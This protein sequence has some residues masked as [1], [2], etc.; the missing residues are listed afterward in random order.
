MEQDAP[1]CKMW[2][3]TDP[4]VEPSGF[5]LSIA[6]SASTVV[7]VPYD[8]SVRAFPIGVRYGGASG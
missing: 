7:W 6:R 3:S 2:I 4:A 1:S 8:R 5:A